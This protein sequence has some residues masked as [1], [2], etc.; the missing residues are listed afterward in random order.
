M[1]IRLLGLPLL[2]VQKIGTDDYKSLK[3][4]LLGMFLLGI[5]TG[6]ERGDHI[7]FNFGVSK[8]ELF[9]GLSLKNSWAR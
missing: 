3:V 7:H 2:K 1:D 6:S 9:I 4:V 5:G 8:F